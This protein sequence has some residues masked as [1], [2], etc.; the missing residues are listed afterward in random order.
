MT[1]FPPLKDSSGWSGLKTLLRGG[2]VIALPV[3][4]AYAL[5]EAPEWDASFV[6]RSEKNRRLFAIKAR[7]PEK[8]IL[9]LAGSL[10]MVGRFARMPETRRARLFLSRWPGFLTLVLPARPLAIHL[11]MAKNGGVAFRIPSDPVLRRFLLHLGTPLSGTSLNLSGK[12]P[13]KSPGEIGREFPFLDGVVDGG[14]RPG[15]PVSTVIDVTKFPPK[16]VRPGILKL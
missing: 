13:L 1:L 11:G 16:I 14:V 5:S 9:Y 10:A 7:S 8:P 4:Y 6:F 12:P 2:G 15:K 3:E